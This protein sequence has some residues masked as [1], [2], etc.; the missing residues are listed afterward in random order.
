MEK[1]QPSKC[2]NAQ[3]WL[4]LDEYERVLLVKEF[5]E[6]SDESLPDDAMELHSSIHVVVENQIAME[7]VPVPATVDRLIRQGL[8]RHEAIHAVGAIVS[9]NI[10]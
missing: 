2:P 1:Y 9:S 7:H 5:H 6:D 3:E 8:D 10:Y 4:E